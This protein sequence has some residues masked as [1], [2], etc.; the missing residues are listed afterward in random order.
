MLNKILILFLILFQF[1]CQLDLVLKETPVVEKGKLNLIFWNFEKMGP[2]FLYGKW[3]FYWNEFID[4]LDPPA[5]NYFT[6]VPS[7]W[8][9]FKLNKNNPKG[10]GFASY[11]AHILL[12]LDGVKR[13]K[14]GLRLKEES[15]AYKLFIDG[16]LIT[17]R[18]ITSKSREASL[19]QY[20]NRTVFFETD[21]EEINITLHIS[22]YHHRNGGMWSTPILGTQE[23]ILLLKYERNFV[24][25]VLGG[26]ILIISIYHFM[27]YFFRR[28]DEPSL[29]FCIFCLITLARIISTGEIFLVQ[30]FPNIPIEIVTKLEYGSFF[31]LAPSFLKFIKVLFPEDIPDQ[32]VKFFSLLGLTMFFLT[33]LTN[34]KIY[35]H[36]TDF[37]YIVILTIVVIIYF[38]LILCITR[39]RIDALTIFIFANIF[40]IFIFNDILG[41]LRII[42]TTDFLPIGVFIFMLSQSIILSRRLS[43]AYRDVE[44]LSIELSSL[45]NAYSNFVPKQFL[46]ILNKKS[47]LDVG[48]GNY[49]E[50]EFTILICGIRGFIQ[51]S[52]HLSSSHVISFLNHY[53]YGVTE[54]IKENN[55]FIDKFVGDDLTAIFPNSPSDAVL[56]SEEI[57]EYLEKFNLNQRETNQRE[58][59]IGMGI[60]TGKVALGTI[61]GKDRMDT[62]IVGETV[63][64]ARTM[65]NLTK[66]FHIPIL[67]TFETFNQLDPEIRKY[68]REIDSVKIN[69][70]EDFITIYEFFKHNNKDLSEKKI[71][72][73]NEFFRGLTLFRAGF[74]EK[75]KII[76][77]NCIESLPDDPVLFIYLNRC[78]D[79]LINKEVNHYYDL[80]KKNTVLVLESNPA[81][82]EYMSI[83]LKKENIEIIHTNNT[84]D[85]ISLLNKMNPYIIFIN[86]EFSTDEFTEFM[87][88]INTSISNFNLKT[89]CIVMSKEANQKKDLYHHNFIDYVLRKPFSKEE[90][91]MIINKYR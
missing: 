8:N 47:I 40:C 78:L 70:R 43:T 56:A 10:S 85:F 15:T 58:I 19:P 49:A 65:E 68:M 64:I 79:L 27:L 72:V 16:E 50:K 63:M 36:F 9:D 86:D 20:G 23:Q 76:F 44:S 24:E 14:L 28:V 87:R 31:L 7:I 6:E 89:V 17:Q 32:L 29:Y 22:N 13:K 34:F 42:H 25:F 41:T 62:T 53:Y 90:L 54:I 80:N 18:G 21:K 12:P 82:Q 26:S 75:A 88:E 37:N 5:T 67:L 30:F 52:K 51:T 84:N 2:I 91:Y 38:Y 71:K 1:S 33:L 48:L 74:T 83:L 69:G 11:S 45:N 46:S 73:S 59:R 55:G 81:I 77:E 3:K 60:H 57:L 61:G 66:S 4:P 39:R 35:N